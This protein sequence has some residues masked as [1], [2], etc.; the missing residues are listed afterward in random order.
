MRLLPRG[1]W[2]PGVHASPP[3]RARPQD[4]VGRDAIPDLRSQLEA[5]L[6]AVWEAEAGWRF[7][8]RLDLAER[9]SR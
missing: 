6:D 1:V 5:T 4:F 7:D 8:D 9:L 3:L 2:W